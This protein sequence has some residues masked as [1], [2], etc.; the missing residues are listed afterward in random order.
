MSLEKNRHIQIVLYFLHNEK[1]VTSDELATLTKASTRTIKNDIHVI[2]DDI[3]EHGFEILS[4]K[5]EGY[6]LNIFDDEACRKYEKNLRIIAHY[7]DTDQELSYQLRI[8]SIIETLLMAKDYVSLDELAEAVFVSKSVIKLDLQKVR[9]YLD[10]YWL[11]LES[12]SNYGIRVVGEELRIRHAM[13]NFYG[14]NVPT[15]DSDLKGDLFYRQLQSD[16]YD[17]VRHVELDV[18]RESHYSIKDNASQGL[19]RY[20]IVSRNRIQAGYPPVVLNDKTKKE[21]DQFEVQKSITQVLFERLKEFDG[22]DFSEDEKYAVQMYLVAYHDYE[23]AEITPN[24][25]KFLFGGIQQ[26]YYEV[27]E[28]IKNTMGLQDEFNHTREQLFYNVARIVTR[29]HFKM[30]PYNRISYGAAYE[31][32]KSNPTAITLASY[33]ASYFEERLFCRLNTKDVLYLAHYFDELLDQ[34]QF[35]YHPLKLVTTSGVGKNYG[36][37][38]V[39]RLND[40][41]GKYIKDNRA[42]ELYEIRPYTKEEID[43]VVIDNMAN[44]YRYD[45]PYVLIRRNNY[46]MLIEGLKNGFDIDEEV[47]ELVSM[48]KIYPNYKFLNHE[49]CFRIL[50]YKY[51]ADDLSIN[52]MIQTFKRHEERIS[53]ARFGFVLLMADYRFIQKNCLEIYKLKDEM[54]WSENLTIHY[55]IFFSVDFAR[56]LKL[57]KALSA[58]MTSLYEDECLFD[59]I[60]Q[61]SDKKDLIKS[62]VLKQISLL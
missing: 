26:M 39:K 8:R 32:V 42:L 55:V 9:W 38:L 18:L 36:E 34:I 33:L 37:L 23:G 16:D 47:N 51:G 29:N 52:E 44:A 31:G 3:K 58:L 56:N 20:L 24:T 25:M 41:F 45:I 48:L 5:S 57:M 7:T 2:N 21:L 49:D 54:V 12:K 15:Y 6:Y 62:A 46:T 10:S 14:I 28:Y 13:I 22:F 30:Q 60:L 43:L 17:E 4:K 1:M 61:A 50:S 35:E 40:K 27:N 19:A 59:E 53:Y 11:K